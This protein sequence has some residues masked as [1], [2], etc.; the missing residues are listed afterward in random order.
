MTDSGLLRAFIDR[1]ARKP[2]GRWARKSY[3]NPRAHQRS[4]RLIMEALRLNDNDIYCEIGCGGGALLTMAMA[5]AKRGAAIDHSR[6]MVE[7]A[8]EN[9]RRAV[10]E[11]R[12][13]ILQGNAE[14]L[15]WESGS[16]TAC[17][18]A[19]MFFFVE[20]PGAMLSEVF[21]VLKPGGRF[22]MVTMGNGLLG[23]ITFGWLY[24]LRTYSDSQMA[25]MLRSAGFSEIRVKSTMG[26]MQ[27]CY[28][29]K[30]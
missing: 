29:T 8:M 18:S 13:E 21:R 23:K 9:N 7:V 4:F 2:E 11:G 10:E 17:A 5:K 15:P 12:L 26:L 6:E 27:A 3:R 16:F 20:N 14:R 30:A 28:G 19:N 25:S 22:S 24:S 1:T